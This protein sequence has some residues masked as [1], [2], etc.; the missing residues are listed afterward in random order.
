MR[1]YLYALAC[2]GQKWQTRGSLRIKRKGVARGWGK[3]GRSSLD[4]R[5][6]AILIDFGKFLADIR[7]SRENLLGFV[8][9]ERK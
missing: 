4:Q 8:F 9:M 3:D 2:H 6:K 1:G 7:G 5:N